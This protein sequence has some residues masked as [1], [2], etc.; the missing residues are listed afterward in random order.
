ML[1]GQR[2]LVAHVDVALVAADGEGADDQ[3]LED[4][5]WVGFQ[6]G[7]VHERA[8]VPLVG[9]ADDVAYAVLALGVA[10][11]FPLFPRREPA[12][13]PTPQARGLDLLDDRFRLHGQGLGQGGIAADGDVVLDAHRLD[14]LVGA[15]D[16]AVL[17]AVEGHRLDAGLLLAGG[18]VHVQEAFDDPVAQQALADDLRYVLGFHPLVEDVPVLED[19]HGLDF[20]EPQA[21]GQAQVHLVGQPGFLELGA[22]GFRYALGAAQDAA[23]G[24]RGDHDLA[25]AIGA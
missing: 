24:V 7:A 17:L 21:A 13:A 11:G 9:V 19:H 5:V 1:H 4:R 10:A 20:A 23:G 12:A 15:Q 16:Q 8:G 6:H 14:A 2:V 3:A 22:E 25:A 18:R